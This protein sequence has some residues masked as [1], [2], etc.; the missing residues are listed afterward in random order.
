MGLGVNWI[1]VLWGVL[2]MIGPHELLIHSMPGARC[3]EHAGAGALYLKN[4]RKNQE[5]SV[6][7]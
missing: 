5:R 4:K 7:A 6:Q 1:V 2:P 3:D